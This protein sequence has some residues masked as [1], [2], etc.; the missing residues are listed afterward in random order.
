MQF[1]D[2]SPKFILISELP[3]VSLLQLLFNCFLN[4]FVDSSSCIYVS[5]YVAF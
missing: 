1:V 4:L 3:S 2:V 5:W